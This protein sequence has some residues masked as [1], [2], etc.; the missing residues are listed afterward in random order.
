MKKIVSIVC[1]A[2]LFM[3]CNIEKKKDGELP[4]VDVDVEA[5]AGELP[6]YDIAWADIN[7]GT[8]TKTVEI[9]KLVVIMEEEEVEVPYIDVDMPDDKWGATEERTIMV[10]AEVSDVEHEIKIDQIWAKENNLFVIA[11]LNKKETS[12]QGKKMRISDQVTLNAPDLNVKYFIVG[13]KPDRAFNSKYNYV[14]SIEEIK[15][16]LEDYT[17]I[18]Q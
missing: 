3:A 7:V 18:Y 1:I 17:V 2:T 6:D 13:E 15:D 4:T 5:D 14:N 11:E 12:L 10:E 8:T 16:R 9:P